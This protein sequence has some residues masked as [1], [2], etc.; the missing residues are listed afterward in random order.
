MPAL[1]CRSLFAAAARS[2]QSMTSMSGRSANASVT[3]PS[4]GASVGNPLGSLSCLCR[5]RLTQ[6]TRAFIDRGLSRVDATQIAHE[7]VDHTVVAPGCDLH[8][9]LLE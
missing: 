6:H 8:A 4:R 7:A 1:T 2:S 3:K 9:G 5:L